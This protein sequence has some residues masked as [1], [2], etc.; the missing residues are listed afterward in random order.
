[1]LLTNRRGELTEEM[2]FVALREGVAPEFVRDEVAR[3]RQRRRRP[4][5]QSISS[6]TP[7]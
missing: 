2:R 4:A 3:G 6:V 7:A 1:V 5:R